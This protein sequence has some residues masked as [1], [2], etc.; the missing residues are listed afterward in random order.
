[1]WGKW[2]M[3]RTFGLNQLPWL[4]QYGTFGYGIPSTDTLERVFATLDP[5][6]FNADF[7]KWIESIRQ[8]VKGE[9]IAINGKAIRGAKARKGDNNMP[10]IVSAFA[11]AN[12]LC[13]GQVKV[14]EKSNEIT[15]I[16]E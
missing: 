11:S 2:G 1:M 9:T 12:G 4:K 3:V 7:I 14:N 10:H 8:E 6:M 15:A 16:P 5:K 13:L